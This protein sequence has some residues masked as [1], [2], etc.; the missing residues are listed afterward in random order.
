MKRFVIFSLLLLIFSVP[1]FSASG[2]L[3]VRQQSLGGLSSAYS[4]D[5][6]DFFR[7]PASIFFYNEKNKFVLST[8]F[9]DIHT[10]TGEP[11]VY[12][13]STYLNTAFI[14]KRL[15]LAISVDN[16]IRSDLDFESGESSFDIIRSATIDI[17]ATA[18][19][20]NFAFG[21]G[22][23]AGSEMEQTQ[24]TLKQDRLLLDLMYDS[25]VGRYSRVEDSEFANV[26]FGFRYNIGQFNFGI[27]ADEVLSFRGSESELSFKHAAE[28]ISAGIHW[29]QDKYYGRGRLKNWVFCAGAELKNIFDKPNRTLCTG[30]EVSLQLI[31]DYSISLRTGIEARLDYMNDM[32]QTIGLGVRLGMFDIGIMTRFPVSFYRDEKGPL[33]VNLDLSILY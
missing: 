14:G 18:G 10:F 27:T 30:A 15:V 3:T 16:T 21:V 25:L 26:N 33:A 20:D 5:A 9:S 32:K 1:L 6:E 31:S 12:R 8:G 13:P 4:S 28:K 17:G 23:S 29:S 7:N 2:A 19:M 24:I 11:L 22:L